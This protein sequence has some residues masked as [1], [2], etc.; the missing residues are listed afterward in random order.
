MSERAASRLLVALAALLP[1]LPALGAGYAVTDDLTFVADN[2]AVR[3]LSIGHLRAMAEST[4]GGVRIPLTWLSF[5][6]DRAVWGP[7]PAGHHLTNL[8]L[9]AATALLF[10]ELCRSLFHRLGLRAAERGAALAAMLFAAHPLRVESV[11]WI[12]ERK[13]VLAGALWTGALVARLRAR[14]SS[15]PARWEAAAL[16]AY[17]LSLAAKPNGLTFPLVL[18]V[19]ERALLR[20]RAPLA[21]YLPYLALSAAAFAA[22]LGAGRARGALQPFDAAWSAGQALY[23]LAFYPLKTLWPSG[24]SIHHPPRAW[25]GTW[26]APLAAHALACAAAVV[27]ARLSPWPRPALSALACYALALLPMLGFVR[28]GIPHAAAERFSYLP[29]MALSAALGAAAASR[30]AALAAASVWVLLLGAASWSRSRDWVGP[31]ALWE[32][33]AA[34]R[35]SAFTLANLGAVQLA[36]GRHREAVGTLR[37]SLALSETDAAVH[38]NLGSAWAALGRHDEAR[39]AWR[40]GLVAA[41]SERLRALLGASLARG[42]AADAREAASLLERAVAAEPGKAGWR[43]DLGDALAA[44]G[45]PGDAARAYESALERDPGLGRALNNLGLLLLRQGRVDAAR[46]RFVAALGTDAAA[47]AQ[48]NLG[49]LASRAGRAPEAER[50]FREA[51]RL[52]P[53]LGAARVNLGNLLAR[54]GALAEAAAQYRAVKKEDRA[55]FEARSNLA[56]VEAALS[57]GR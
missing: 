22:T 6:L 11:V 52:D 49:L 33:A 41:P 19:V 48:H 37:A 24:L 31:L 7:G 26:S 17:A 53:G 56:A 23:G 46:V 39:A 47:E 15:R 51:V 1:F 57:R 4:L 34:T 32:S 36:Q 42:T 10:L 8:L 12:A 55:S 35:P 18:L 14:E 2:P 21:G 38:E 16:G 27:A 45:R 40:R 20:V 28:H 25:F 43:A 3:G 44:S 50:R 30:R 13:G 5:A 9:H 54:R 29:A